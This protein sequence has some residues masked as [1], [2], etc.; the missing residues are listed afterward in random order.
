MFLVIVYYDVLFALLLLLL[1]SAGFA[2]VGGFLLFLSLS[3]N[4]TSPFS[5]LAGRLQ[6]DVIC[7][8]V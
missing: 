6:D 2:V 5:L 4:R 7:Q 3:Q 8:T 1:R